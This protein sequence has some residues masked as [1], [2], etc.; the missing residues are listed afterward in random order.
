MTALTVRAGRREIGKIARASREKTR[1]PFPCNNI[2]TEIQRKSTAALFCFRGAGV[3]ADLPVS[4]CAKGLKGRYFCSDA[5]LFVSFTASR[6]VADTN[7]PY[8][9]CDAS[10]FADFTA[11]LWIWFK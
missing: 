8:C 7:N 5:G 11:P 2:F 9:P 4:R 10:D 6:C 3:L 1:I